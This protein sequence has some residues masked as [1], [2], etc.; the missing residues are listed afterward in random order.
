MSILIQDCRFALR[1]FRRYRTSVVLTIVVVAMSIGINVATYSAVHALLLRKLPFRS[2]EQLVDIEMITPALRASAKL[3]QTPTFAAFAAWRNHNST[4]E[5]LAA[6]TFEHPTLTGAGYAERVSTVGVSSNL[7]PMLG[8]RPLIG[9][10]FTPE[11][12]V[13]GAARTVLLSFPFWKN[14]FGADSTI[15]G[16]S[17]ILDGSA[18]RVVGIMPSSF[19]FP[20]LPAAV[21]E[22]QADLWAPLGV[23]M[24]EETPAARDGEP[25]WVL[26]RLR[27]SISR[28]A[29]SRDLDVIAAANVAFQPD[30]AWRATLL[31][32]LRDLAMI[33]V[34][35]PLLLM[36]GAS[37][38]VLLVGCSNAAS[39]FVARAI[40]RDHEIALR[41]A[42]GASRARILRQLST[43]SL[44][45]TVIAGAIGILSAV[46]I[47]PALA[48]LSRST[49]PDIGD[50]H[51]DTNVLATSVLSIIIIGLFFGVAPALHLF[52]SA[53]TAL[54]QGSRAGSS[55]GHSRV[56]DILVV[57]EVAVTVVLLTGA[58]LLL[59]SF[60]KIISIDP[61]F[62]SDHVLVARF[63]L[64][65]ARYDN[66]QKR[67]DFARAALDQA[68]R[69]SG[70]KLAAVATGSP[71]AGGGFSVV[72]RPGSTVLMSAQPAWIVAASPEYF[73]VLEI[74]SD[75]GSSL[76]ALT[77]SDAVLI[78]VEAAHTFFPGREPLGERLAWRLDKERGTV[79]G[80]VGTVRQDSP[81]SPAPPHIYTPLERGGSRSFQ[82]LARTEGDPSRY[83]EAMRHALAELDPELP[84]DRI[85]SL[86]DLLS[87]T[88]ASHRF[89]AIFVALFGVAALLMALSGVY[90]MAHLAAQARL[91]ELGIRAALG[92]S[93]RHLFRVVAA[94]GLMLAASGVLLGTLAALAFTR[95]MRAFLYGVETW[96]PTS[97]VSVFILMLLASFV[98]TYFPGRRAMQADPL[99]VLRSA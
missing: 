94:R 21:G 36:L 1:N 87:A 26:G 44:L 76:D 68:R 53:A 62:R 69:I 80:V 32:P 84:I 90:A 86:D 14:R 37:L 54:R 7:F 96:D 35:M 8:V 20:I 74:P 67:I 38:F 65:G 33:N 55:L 24:Q 98:A 64:A 4:F 77:G 89:Y 72:N 97:V 51:V 3:G 31:T 48:G 52:R 50:V 13:P 42:L 47:T 41:S 79:A 81:L 40:A 83:R 16:R 9:H 99:S 60:S 61:G 78:D 82:I 5:D 63:S 12:D 85:V 15:I 56:H 23:A 43:E 71:L 73:R 25:V 18:Y 27:H 70:V 66:A 88:H 49:F 34:R 95:W 2:P 57:L 59:H 58:S 75:A 39:F 17:I 45:F 11:E 92:A 6:Y 10:T 30:D 91:P 93:P 46:W 19:R 22:S 29:A 28:A